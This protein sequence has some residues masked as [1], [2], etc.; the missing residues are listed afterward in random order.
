MTMLPKNIDTEEAF[1]SFSVEY[2]CDY[3]IDDFMAEYQVSKRLADSLLKDIDHISISQSLFVRLNE[4][5]RKKFFN[6]S[7]VFESLLMSRKLIYNLKYFKRAGLG[8]RMKETEVTA[9]YIPAI[10]VLQ[11]AEL[12]YDL[13]VHGV[14]P[15]EATGLIDSPKKTINNRYKQIEGVEILLGDNEKKQ[16]RRLY[17]LDKDDQNYT[18]IIDMIYMPPYMMVSIF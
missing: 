1:N 16:V 3:T 2:D 8:T 10:Y 6:R 5:S 9:E 12:F 4:I 18:G 11:R 15:K 7:H 14:S 17:V 13:L